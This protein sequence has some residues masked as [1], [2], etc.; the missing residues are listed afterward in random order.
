MV[1][2]S[3]ACLNPLSQADSVVADLGGG[4]GGGG[5]SSS[6]IYNINNTKYNQVRTVVDST[7]FKNTHFLA[8]CSFL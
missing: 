2:T 3:L 5:S 4:G 6:S 8:Q 7:F 1:P